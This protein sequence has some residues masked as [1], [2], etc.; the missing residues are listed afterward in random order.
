MTAVPHGT[1]GQKNYIT[2]GTEEGGGKGETLPY[3]DWLAPVKI[4]F[5]IPGPPSFP[6]LNTAHA[7]V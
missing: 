1:G 4:V 3:V 2:T 5:V 6:L 7:N